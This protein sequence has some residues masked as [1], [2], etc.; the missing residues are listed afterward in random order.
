MQIC[1]W[2]YPPH[3][4]TRWNEK[5]INYLL[6]SEEFKVLDVKFEPLS[7]IKCTESI[8]TYIQGLFIKNK[9]NSINEKFYRNKK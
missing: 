2:D 3:H 4:L 5:S 6:N 1:P 9:N 8:G 7:I